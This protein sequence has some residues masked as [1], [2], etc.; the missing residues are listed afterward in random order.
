MK[1]IGLVTYYQRNY[2]SCLQAFAL[3]QILMNNGYE[4][5]II[6]Y[7]DGICKNIAKKIYF[8]SFLIRNFSYYKNVMT[9][10]NWNK[11]NLNISK[12]IYGSKRMVKFEKKFDLFIVGS[13]QVWNVRENKGYDFYFLRFTNKNKRFAYAPSLGKNNIIESQKENVSTY[14][15]GFN[16]LSLREMCS[17]NYIKDEFNLESTHVLDPTLLYD[18][19]FW[20]KYIKQTNEEYIF[21]YTLTENNSYENYINN[22]SK[23]LNIKIKNIAIINTSKNGLINVDPFDFLSLIANAKYIVTDSFHGCL[24]SII[25]KKQFIALKRFSD[26]DILSQNS[27][28]YDIM[29]LLNL[30]DRISGDVLEFDKIL[31]KNIDYSKINTILSEMKGL[32]IKYLLESLDDVIV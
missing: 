27:R 25:F 15:N 29:N 13:D 26:E 4:V 16:K 5:Q 21:Y 9:F 12:T 6:N 8:K 10:Y 28:I 7:E 11:N 22:I 32:S 30:V 18:S 2:G 24:F 19:S 14:L 31:F 20:S 23:R 3:Q 1:K 17:V